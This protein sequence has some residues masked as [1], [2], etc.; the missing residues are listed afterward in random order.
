MILNKTW[1]EYL[2]KQY[3]E[4]EENESILENKIFESIK[5][6]GSPPSY[7]TKDILMNIAKWKARRVKGY[8]E[9]NEDQY[10]RDTTQVSLATKNEK[11]K[12]EVLTLL[13]GVKIRMASA[14]L[15]FCYPEQYTVMDYRAWDSLKALNKIDGE[16]DDTFGGWQMYNETCRKIAK[17]TG[18]SLRKLDKALWQYKGG[19]K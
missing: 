16:I 9:K 14:I 19:V 6:I 4:A 1:I 17:Q 12:I 3:D 10:V 8:V 11:L 2:A 13:N 7:L 18:V 15:F 5:E